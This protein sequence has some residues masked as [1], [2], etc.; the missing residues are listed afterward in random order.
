MRFS[1]LVV[2][3]CLAVAVNLAVGAPVNLVYINGVQ[4]TPEDACQTKNEIRKVLQASVL[5]I[6]P[7]KREFALS[8]VWNPIGW[9]GTADVS[10]PAQ[11]LMELFLLKTAEENYRSDFHKILAPHNALR[12][13]DQAASAAATRI[14]KKFLDDMTPGSNS[15][16]TNGWISDAEMAVTQRAARALAVRIKNLKHSVVVAHSQG[17]LLANLAYAS[18]VSE[19]GDEVATMVRVVNVANTSE[20]SVHNLNLTHSKDG[21][22]ALLEI[23]PFAQVWNR[24]TTECSDDSLCRFVVDAPTLAA[25]DNACALDLFAHNVARTYLS[26]CTV[27]VLDARGVDFTPGAERFVDRF[28]DLVYTAAASLLTPAT[29]PPVEYVVTSMGNMSVY[30]INDAGMVAGRCG[31][32]ACVFTPTADGRSGTHA[33]LGTLGGTESTARSINGTG[34]VVGDSL[35]DP[36]LGYH[37]FL[38]P[39]VGRGPMVDLFS[40]VSGHSEAVAINA[41]G[42]IAGNYSPSFT[43]PFLRRLNGDIT[44]LG[45]VDGYAFA[46]ASGLNKFHHVVGFSYNPNPWGVGTAFLYKSQGAL[47][48]IGEA[49]KLKGLSSNAIAINDFGI[50][51]GTYKPDAF[52]PDSRAYEYY[53]FVYDNGA[54][55]LIPGFEVG[56][57]YRD[58]KYNGPADINA[59]GEIVGS[60]NG[61]AYIYRT[62][63]MSDLNAT[64][65][66]F[67]GWR[68]V[69]AV[70]I[71][72]NGQIAG[73]GRLN[74]VPMAFLLTPKR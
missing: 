67:P 68:L 26:D 44:D 34:Q 28:E 17:N 69:R 30:G 5:H 35:T 2:G 12:T 72:S 74:G 53:G 40:G 41:L 7:L 22:L 31:Q 65:P 73:E 37:A 71:N 16:E 49:E 56:P 60:S 27:P 55:T 29:P 21:A 6:G 23:L 3:L 19:L 8:I 61:L 50:V 52:A 36:Y 33:S 25:P 10:A 13:F 70:R 48:N 24:T 46:V 51:I 43:H 63:A 9:N 38:H 15:L 18:V 4:N 42:S 20:F 54:V 1:N 47:I 64:I 66:E 62:G 11:D 39:G 58:T 57:D 14:K 45:T 32:V 59:R